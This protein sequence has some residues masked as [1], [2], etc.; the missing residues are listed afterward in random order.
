MKPVPDLL[1]LVLCEIYHF[2]MHSSHQ[3]S[4]RNAPNCL[5]PTKNKK[6]S[7]PIPKNFRPDMG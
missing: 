7:V 3:R 6:N 4:Y 2:E 5:N 1:I